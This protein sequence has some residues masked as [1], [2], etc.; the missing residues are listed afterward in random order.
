MDKVMN[1]RTILIALVIAFL[2]A[3]AV[4][5]FYKQSK[6]KHGLISI[7]KVTGLNCECCKD[8]IEEAL[9][10][11]PTIND[12]YLDWTTKKLFVSSLDKNSLTQDIK[13]IIAHE[14][15]GIRI[16]LRDEEPINQESC[17]EYFDIQTGLHK[18]NEA[19]GCLKFLGKAS[20]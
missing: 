14:F 17:L 2:M 7:Y 9:M 15:E 18:N 8:K 3:F 20:L 12:A 1:K 19:G 13:N 16:W 5:N 11:I 10:F 6:L 4:S